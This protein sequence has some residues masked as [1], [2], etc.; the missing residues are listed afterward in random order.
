MPSAQSATTG[1]ISGTVTDN[2]GAL[3]PGVTVTVKSI[4][5]GAALTVKSGGSGEYTVPDLDPGIYTA[6]FTSDGFE[7]YQ[8]NSIAVTVGSISTVS[9][10]LKVGSASNSVSVTDETPVMHTESS[11]ISTTLDQAAIDNLP[12]NGRRWSDFALLTPGVVSNSRRLSDC[13]AF[14]ASASC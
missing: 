9:P 2:G 14:A 6:T 5:T 4:S 3:L 7:T 1:A 12:V 11:A 10:A 8:E 13:S